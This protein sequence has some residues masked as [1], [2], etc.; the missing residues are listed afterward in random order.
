LRR[1]LKNSAVFPPDTPLLT[2]LVLTNIPVHAACKL[3]RSP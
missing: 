3:L 1:C 2:G